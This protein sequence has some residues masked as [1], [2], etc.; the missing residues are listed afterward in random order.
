MAPETLPGMLSRASSDSDRMLRKLQSFETSL[1]RTEAE[2]APLRSSTAS[3]I[4]AKERISGVLLEMGKTHEYFQVSQSVRNIAYQGYSIHRAAQIFSAVER[5]VKARNFFEVNKDIRSAESILAQINQLL[6]VLLESCMKELTFQYDKI[7]SGVIFEGNGLAQKYRATDKVPGD[8][9]KVL[10]PIIDMLTRIESDEHLETYRR[11]RANSVESEL[12][13]FYM[14]RKSD[15]DTLFYGD[16]GRSCFQVKTNGVFSHF[17][18]FGT[19][20]LRGEIFLWSALLPPTERSIDVFVTLCMV[21]VKRVVA[22]VTPFLSDIVEKEKRGEKSRESLRNDHDKVLISFEIAISFMEYFDHLYEVCKPD[23]CKES[24]ASRALLE[25]R[26]ELFASTVRRLE[27]LMTM[28]SDLT[29][30]HFP[31]SLQEQIGPGNVGEVCDL[32]TAVIRTL[33]CCRELMNLETEFES[34]MEISDEYNLEMHGAPCLRD[35]SELIMTMLRNL[36][37]GIVEKGEFIAAATSAIASQNLDT[38]QSNAIRSFI[39]DSRNERMSLVAS[40][41]LQLDNATNT[42]SLF[43][44]VETESEEATIAM[45]GACQYLFLSN[46]LHQLHSFVVDTVNLLQVCLG[47]SDPK[48]IDLFIVELRD[49]CLQSK[50]M[51]CQTVAGNLRMTL[52]DEEDFHCRYAAFPK[53]DKQSRGRLVK[54][55]F[56]LFNRAMEA[57]L[58]QQGAWKVT[59]PTLRDELG[60][61]LAETVGPLYERFYHEHS[62][63]NFSKRHMDQYVRF[64]PEEVTTAL[65]RFFSGNM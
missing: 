2:L 47:K 50:A 54:G 45:M 19:E 57:L 38:K 52:S 23:F 34:F 35:V 41:Q 56:A 27:Y 42:H 22:L 32:Q 25:L 8:L 63:T 11:I 12:D 9:V 44:Q 4:M 49:S 62:C 59:A 65:R 5:L 13:N 3:I 30:T 60:V 21:M 1:E 40:N 39:A 46:N 28:A 26:N 53:S 14:N 31:K 61:S 36:K 16:G 48:C 58:S 24:F 10:H 18:R 43:H 64:L 6:S 51:F 33:H 37:I 7:G 29:L 17:M 15:W 20:L 55:K